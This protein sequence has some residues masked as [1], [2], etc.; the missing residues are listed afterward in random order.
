MADRYQNRPF[1]AAD[2]YDGG[3]YPE[4]AKADSD[5]LAELAG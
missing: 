5:P 2:D 1:P 3:A 4:A